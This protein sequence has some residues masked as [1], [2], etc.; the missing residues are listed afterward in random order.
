MS[1]VSATMRAAVEERAGHRCEYCHLP[2]RGQMAPFPID[3]LIPLS[4][5][6]PTSLDNLALSCPVCNGH[7][8][9]Y[10]A[11]PDP[12]SGEAVPLFNPRTDVWSRHFE[13]SREQR[14]V[15]VGKTP[16]GRATIARL[17]INRLDLVATRQL[18]AGLSLFPEVLG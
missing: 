2:T 10:V 8:W 4:Q 7:K 14:G 11:W 5:A 1:V 12:E 18:L 6:G 9:K 16:C 3:H 15:L 17:Q 13:W